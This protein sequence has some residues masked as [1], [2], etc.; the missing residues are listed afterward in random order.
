MW[1]KG[2]RGVA[3]PG[4]PARRR[5]PCGGRLWTLGGGRLPTFQKLPQTGTLASCSASEAAAQNRFRLGALVCAAMGC[6]ERA[7]DGR[8]G[9]TCGRPRFLCCFRGKP[10]LFSVEGGA[11]SP[12]LEG[13][14]LV[15]TPRAA[16]TGR[17]AQALPGRRSVRRGRVCRLWKPP[18]HLRVTGA[19]LR[20]RGR[21]RHQETALPMGEERVCRWR[22]PRPSAVSLVPWTHAGRTASSRA[23]VSAGARQAVGTRQGVRTRGADPGCRGTKAPQPA[24][25]GHCSLVQRVTSC[26]PRASCPR[27]GERRGRRGGAMR[28]PARLSTLRSECYTHTR[29]SRRRARAYPGLSR[30]RVSGGAAPCPLREGPQRRGCRRLLGD[31]SGEQSDGDAA[32]APAPGLGDC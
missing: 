14:L 15:G 31:P 2:L 5:G 18:A 1:S 12:R 24:A 6:D 13:D 7:Q 10:F 25:A 20:A 16:S 27:G 30:A 19:S 29:A 21:Q 3:W 8:A 28:V 9:S 4:Q 32:W 23:R 11:G 22:C 26:P 17:S